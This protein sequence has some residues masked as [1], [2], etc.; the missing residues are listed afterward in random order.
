MYKICKTKPS[1]KRQYDIMNAFLELLQKKHVRDITVTELCTYAK[2]PRKTFYRYFESIEDIFDYWT[3]QINRELYQAV[4]TEE[5]SLEN[6]KDVLVTFF[7]YWDKNHTAIH[8][9]RNNQLSQSFFS[10]LIEN[11]SMNTLYTGKMKEE[12]FQIRIRIIFPSLISI[13]Y[14]W[15]DQNYSYTPEE[16]A[17]MTY[18]AL[19]TPIL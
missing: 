17:N 3:D 8:I 12:E 13:L 9:I 2:I 10:R 15:D 4:N 11:A 16:L 14:L 5:L 18:T 1:K 7:Q 6:L 19:T